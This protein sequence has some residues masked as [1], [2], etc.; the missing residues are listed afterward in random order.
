[1]QFYIIGNIT[2]DDFFA[3]CANEAKALEFSF[4]E[5]ICYMRIVKFSVQCKMFSVTILLLGD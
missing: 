5:A 4:S 1:M 3:Q 2:S